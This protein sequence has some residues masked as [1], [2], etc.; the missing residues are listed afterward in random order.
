MG[1]GELIRSLGSDK[2][3]LSA[4]MILGAAG[5]CL[6]LISSLLPGVKEKEY[7][8]AESCTVTSMSEDYCKETEKRL[9]EFLRKIEG[10]GEVE[11]YLTVSNEEEYVYATE[12]KSSESENKKEEEYQYV[13]VGGSGDKTAL[14]E[15]VKAPQISGAV[16]A[17]S[18][19]DSP[20]VQEM[21]Y[22]AV[23]T[24][25]GIPTS[26]IYVTSLK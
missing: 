5:L 18:G 20:V 26:R 4:V 6:I 3:A 16:I 19:C 11:V 17:C 22:K 23:S 15:T 10:V 9:S 2:K 25:L 14:I 24:A 1:I 13:M 21:V 8:T 12:G 7:K